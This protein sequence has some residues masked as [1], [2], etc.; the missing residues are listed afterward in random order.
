MMIEPSCKCNTSVFSEVVFQ[1]M[2]GQF[3]LIVSAVGKE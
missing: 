3:P 2:E 1:K